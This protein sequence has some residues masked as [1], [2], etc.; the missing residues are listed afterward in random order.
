MQLVKG[1][2]RWRIEFWFAGGSHVGSDVGILYGLGALQVRKNGVKQTAG[3]SYEKS[4]QRRLIIKGI[5]GLGRR[6][7]EGG[8]VTVQ[9][10][11]SNV[12]TTASADSL[13]ACSG[14]LVSTTYTSSVLVPPE[15]APY[16][17]FKLYVDR[18]TLDGSNN[19]IFPHDIRVIIEIEA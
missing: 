9:A 6:H 13:P 4:D 15:G 14:N 1:T 7:Y 3:L 19:S 17:V 10:N 18:P 16:E 2:T 11:V 8:R 5:E 12:D